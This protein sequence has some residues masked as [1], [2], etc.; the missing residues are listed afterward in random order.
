[1]LFLLI[2]LLVFISAASSLL[3]M[4]LSQA[5]KLIHPKRRPI[6]L[7]PADVGIG[8]WEDVEFQTADGITLRGWFIP[9]KGV[10]DGSTVIGIHGLG[11]NRLRFLEQAALLRKQGYGML[12]FDLRNHGESDGTITSLSLYEVHD[13]QAAVEYLRGRSDVHP[14]RIVLMGHSMGAATALRATAHIAGIRGVVAVAPFASLTENVDEGVRTFVGW[15]GVVI[16]PLII[17]L[18]EYRLGARAH[19]VRPIDALDHFGERPLLLIHGS[20]DQ[21]IHPRNSRRLLEARPTHTLLHEVDKAGHNSVLS[22]RFFPSYQDMLLNFLETGVKTK[23]VMPQR[24][25]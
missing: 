20:E 10:S 25:A 15:A 21:V 1:M 13:V 6:T 12:L 7:S 4:A 2:A 24:A 22:E 8:Y 18:C 3:Y 19:Q 23:P 16:A 5:R 17:W 14:E 9:A 11:S